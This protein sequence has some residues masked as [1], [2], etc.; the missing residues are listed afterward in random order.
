MTVKAILAKKGNKV[1]SLRSEM[2]TQEVVELF[3]TYGIGAAPVID[4]GRLVGIVSERDI[5]R[6]IAHEGASVLHREVTDVMTR[7][8]KTC[9]LSETADNV[10]CRMTEG[11]FRHMP[12]VDQGQIVGMISIGDVVAARK[13][14]ATRAS[15][16]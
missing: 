12:V 2:T 4:G 5:V 1:I 3:A 13:W 16:S 15:K 7:G 14:R 8:V 9:T 11:R 10:M 6:T